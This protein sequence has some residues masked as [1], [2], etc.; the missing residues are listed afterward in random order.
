MVGALLTAV[1]VCLFCV[2]AVFQG[3]C[4]GPSVISFHI[5]MFEVVFPSISYLCLFYYFLRGFS[6]CWSCSIRLRVSLKR[7]TIY[8]GVDSAL[9]LSL[10]HYF[11]KQFSGSSLSSASGTPIV[12][13]LTSLM[14]FQKSHKVTLLLK[15]IYFSFSFCCFLLV[16]SI[17]LSSCSLIYF[18]PYP[19]AIEYLWCNFQ[20]NFNFCLVFPYIFS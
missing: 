9:D 15:I 10:N 14:L 5:T 19:S 12:Q 4:S 1:Y 11:F 7:I 6:M 3:L 8:I 18:L 20:F 17:P 13:M 2:F 16:S